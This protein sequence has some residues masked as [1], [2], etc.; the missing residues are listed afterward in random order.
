MLN[1]KNA[2]SN[3]NKVL[4]EPIQ[5]SQIDDENLEPQF[6]RIRSG[7]LGTLSIGSTNVLTNP[8][9]PA[10]IFINPNSLSTRKVRRLGVTAILFSMRIPNIN[11]NNF[12]VGI[13]SS[14]TGRFHYVNLTENYYTT[15]AQ[16]MIELV[17]KLNTL[18][19]ASG[20]SFIATFNAIDNTVYTISATGGTFYFDPNSSLV[21]SIFLINLDNSTNLSIAKVAGPIQLIYTRYIDI[22]SSELTQYDK[23]PTISTDQISKTGNILRLFLFSGGPNTPNPGVPY[24]NYYT[25]DNIRWFNYNKTHSIG[26]IDLTFYDESGQY[27]YIPN[28]GNSNTFTNFWIK[29]VLTTEL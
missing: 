22:I 16:L 1:Y 26:A 8:N 23:N 24:S 21:K 13:F 17:S 15:P 5:D 12:T 2:Y 18:S 7:N 19:G 25:Y 28:Y 6:V 20:L 27:L 10:I 14:I 11:P 29:L 4:L 3:Y 9:N